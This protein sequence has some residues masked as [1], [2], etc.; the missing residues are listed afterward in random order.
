MCSCMEITNSTLFLEKDARM[1]SFMAKGVASD[2][3][4]ER[5]ARVSGKKCAI[6]NKK[7]TYL[8]T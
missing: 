8:N 4:L 2:K 5:L 3:S 1:I 7:V 6:F